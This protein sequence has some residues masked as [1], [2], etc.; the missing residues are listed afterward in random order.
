MVI[1][2]KNIKEKSKVC[3]NFVEEIIIYTVFFIL[4]TKEYVKDD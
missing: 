1:S 3:D 4:K 2:R